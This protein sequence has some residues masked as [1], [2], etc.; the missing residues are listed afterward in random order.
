MF[1]PRRGSLGLMSLLDFKVKRVDTVNVRCMCRIYSLDVYTVPWKYTHT[2][3]HTHTHVQV[4]T[5]K[6]DTM[7][8]I[9]L[10]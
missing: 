10:V 5:H 1:L 7:K 6:Q 3:A 4:D 2:H 9:H 8:K